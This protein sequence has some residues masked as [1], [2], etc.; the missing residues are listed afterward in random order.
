MWKNINYNVYI[1]LDEKV[2]FSNLKKIINKAIYNNYE[3]LT[4]ASHLK[5]NFILKFNEQNVVKNVDINDSKEKPSIFILNTS[6][7]IIFDPDYLRKGILFSSE[8][9][10]IEY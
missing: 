7:G 4:Y 10:N 1:K 5:Q 6:K 2:S 8:N 3:S 9:S